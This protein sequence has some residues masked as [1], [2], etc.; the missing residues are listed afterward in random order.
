MFRIDNLLKYY[1]EIRLPSNSVCALNSIEPKKNVEEI[2]SNTQTTKDKIERKKNIRNEDIF[3]R[4]SK[5]V[6]LFSQ[7]NKMKTRQRSQK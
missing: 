6:T 4:M 1:R 5:F 3:E 7:L 2:L